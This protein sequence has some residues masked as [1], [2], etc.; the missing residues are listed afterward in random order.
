MKQ[1]LGLLAALAFALDVAGTTWG[2]PARWHPDEKADSAARMAKDGTLAPDSFINPSL[3]VYAMVPAIWAQQRAADAGLLKGRASDPV[4]AGRLLSAG[5]GAMAV[6]L[7]GLLGARLSPG[8]GL[9]GAA[10]LAVAPG[11]VNL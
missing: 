3:S 5:A 1:R 7:T 10:L 2:L 6:F 9:L 8:I 11:M 4:V